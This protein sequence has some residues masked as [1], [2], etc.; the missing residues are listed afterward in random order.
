[1]ERG[2]STLPTFVGGKWGTP[3]L[4]LGPVLVDPILASAFGFVQLAEGILG[5]RSWQA[6]AMCPA[7]ELP[8]QADAS[9]ALWVPVARCR[10]LRRKGVFQITSP[11][12]SMVL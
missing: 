9:R 7:L 11:V 5:R 12:A 1:M 3:S 4:P 8:E 2:R 6:G 10:P